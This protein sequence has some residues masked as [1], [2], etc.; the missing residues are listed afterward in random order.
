MHPHRHLGIPV[1]Q[2]LVFGSTP[3]LTLFISSFLTVFFPTEVIN[4][5]R[6]ISVHGYRMLFMKQFSIFAKPMKVRILM[7]KATQNNKFM[8]FSTSIEIPFSLNSH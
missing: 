4:L 1:L 2:E 3:N 6:Q 5:S 7:K 8:L